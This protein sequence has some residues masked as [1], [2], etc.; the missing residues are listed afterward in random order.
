M[1]KYFLFL[2]LIGTQ[3]VVFIFS[4]Y[5]LKTQSLYVNELIQQ[6]GAKEVEAFFE[7]RRKWGWL[8]Y[9]F[10]PLK[11]LVKTSFTAICAS[12]G[13][14]FVSNRFKFKTL[15]SVSLE[16][17]F[18][19]LLPVFSKMFWFGFI[20]TDYNHTD[21][22]T[23]FPL[24]LFNLFDAEHLDPWLFYP[25]QLINVFELIYCFFLFRRAEEKMP[26][27]GLT[28]LVSYGIGLLLWVCAIMFLTL[29]FSP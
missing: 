16:A 12:I 24:S 25:L 17:E 21:L 4:D 9:L 5:F 6:V 11:T 10:I 22:Q 7:Y 28:V 29:T 14:F 8:F 13:V 27:T 15:F 19:F 1:N 20:Q 2:L 26:G 3:F 23:F 18:L